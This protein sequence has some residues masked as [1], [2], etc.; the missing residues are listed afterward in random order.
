MEPAAAAQL[1]I[2]GE[3]PDLDGATTWLNSERLSRRL[4]GIEIDPIY[5]E[6]AIA[7]WE[8]FTGQRAKGKGRPR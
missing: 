7:R 1:P 2:E 4:Y 5:L 3:F 6:V 8:A